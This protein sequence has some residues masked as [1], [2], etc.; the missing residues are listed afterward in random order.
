[1][2]DNGFVFTRYML[3]V[4]FL[5]FIFEACSNTNEISTEQLSSLK[6]VYQTN[7]YFK[8]RTALESLPEY[9]NPEVL[10]YNAVSKNVFNAPFES[11]V[12][13]DKVIQNSIST[14]SL[15]SDALIIKINNLVKMGKY[16]EAYNASNK[17]IDEYAHSTDSSSLHS[18]INQRLI[19]KALSDTDPMSVQAKGNTVIKLTPDKA[20]LDR[21]PLSISGN[22]NEF[23]LDTGANFSVIQRSVA[24]KHGLEIV[25][26]NFEVAGFTGQ[27]SESDIAIA[28]ELTIGNHTFKNVVFLVF[29]DEVLNFPQADYSIEGIV[30][31]PVFEVAKELKIRNKENSIEIPQTVGK[32][33]TRNLAM[34]GFT[35]IVQIEYKDEGL[36]GT[37]D[38]GAAATVFYSTFT[39][40]YSSEI[41]SINYEEQDFKEGGAGGTKIV[42][43]FSI[44]SIEINIGNKKVQIPDVRAFS[45]PITGE[46]TRFA[47][48]GQDVINQFDLLILN[49]ES[50]SLILK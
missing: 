49:F 50:M 39:D 47:N 10:Y 48:I 32:Y 37:F 16:G 26:A 15:I 44:S 30:G 19:W 2:K 3:S 12:Y 29:E 34:D 43:G 6:D 23:V 41:N 33:N 17:L 9:E 14:D 4:I 20:G 11:T 31:F 46:E 35:P 18:Q 25:D 38:T 28:R 42:K 7:D 27:M 13:A 24:I 45:E 21:I 40:K 22:E 5:S 1:M 8:L 36:I